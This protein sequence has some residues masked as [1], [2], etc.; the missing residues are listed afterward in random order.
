MLVREH[1][2]DEQGLS[3]LLNYA[4]IG[5]GVIYNKDGAL[6]CSA[7][8]I[9]PELD[10][11]SKGE[12]DGLV[13]VFNRFALNF[14][15]GWMIHTDDIRV[16]ATEYPNMSAFPCVVAK[17][18]DDE[19]REQYE[20]V[21]DHYENM[22]FLT[23]VW[24]FPKETIKINKS[25]F[26]ENLEDTEKHENLTS[27]LNNH[28][29]PVVNRCLNTLS[30]YFNMELLD[31]ADLLTFLNFCITGKFKPRQVPS[32]DM[33]LDVYMAS[34][35]FIGGL[36]PKIGDKHIQTLTIMGVKL[37]ETYPGILEALSTYPL[38]YRLSNRFIPFSQ[39]TAD[40]E[41]K[42]YRKQWNNKISGFLGLVMEALLNKPSKNQDEH[43]GI[44]KDEVKNAITWNNSGN[45]IF[46][47]WTCQIV[48]MSEEMAT[49]EYAIKDFK[50]FLDSAGFDS[51]LEDINAVDAY[52]GTIPGHGSCNARRV[53]V[54]SRQLSHL[55]PLG[56]LWAGDEKVS[57]SSLLPKDAPVC[58]MANATGNTPFRYNVDHQ[59][60]GHGVT[61]GPTGAGKTTFEQFKMT[62]FYR[63][64]NA[65]GFI[66]DKDLSQYGWT[67]AMGGK[68]YHIGED[69]SLGFAPFQ[70]LE[71]NTQLNQAKLFV[72]MLC[73]LQNMKISPKERQYIS[74]GV[75][76][77]SKVPI[78]EDRSI[79][80]LISNIH[81][82][83]KEPLRFYALDGSFTMLDSMVDSVE[84]GYLHC[85]E[86]GWLIKQKH[87]YYMPVLMHQFN[88]I[89]NFLEKAATTKPT[90]IYLEEAWQYIE[91]EAFSKY[92]VD[93]A[94]TLR[95][96][97]ARLW[98][99]TQSLADLYDPSTGKLKASTAAILDACS[100]RVFLPN[101]QMDSSIED[102]YRQI[103]LTDRQI[104]IVK[105]SE[106]KRQYYV[107]RPPL[108]DSKNQFSGN[109]LFDLGW[110][111][112]EKKPL[113]LSFIGL[114]P[115]KSKA[116]AQLIKSYPNEEDWL[117]IWLEQEG[118]TEWLEHYYDKYY[119]KD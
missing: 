75:N 100:T 9:G 114:N 72:E 90:F 44:M 118:Q 21:G 52:L 108:E 78:G 32:E 103:G 95:K 38:V 113:A 16:P 92:I 13:E 37:D 85:F 64:P 88:T 5:N 61:L 71:T 63:Y 60:I 2:S 55:L 82:S 98:L 53:F 70:N 49:L 34:E 17:M 8:Y 22:Q 43:A 54:N 50:G 15:D 31:S 58:F 11:A 29:M 91:H 25:Y 57:R 62:Q 93:W 111:N 99:A 51:L 119:K 87:Q 107:V 10:S 80:A 35:P 105:S 81:E 68:H 77:L 45:V 18:I 3:D 79:T 33:F 86:M 97:N 46:G 109:R 94:K 28:F 56:S 69:D 110:T 42:K 26:I 67:Y 20:G 4:H 117:P 96:F 76:R 59:D 73:E 14:S 47:Y 6:I 84:D 89:T 102:L 36:I 115:G 48:F 41:L 106:P 74:D 24:K 39:A 27:F 112:L 23:F 104:E 66:F 101:V 1:R 7:R 19:R 83:I 65:H 30:S 40:K 116:L 12:L